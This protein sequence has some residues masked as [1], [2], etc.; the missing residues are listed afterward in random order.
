MLRLEELCRR[1]GLPLPGGGGWMSHRAVS[2]LHSWVMADWK[3]ES[4]QNRYR[5]ST[6]SP[7]G[8]T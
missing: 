2:A 1:L 7:A 3:P 8:T 6:A 4:G 5:P